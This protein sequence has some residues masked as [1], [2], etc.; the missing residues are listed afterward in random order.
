ML[1]PLPIVCIKVGGESGTVA[2][3]KPLWTTAVC[4]DLA[5]CLP[6]LKI[7]NLKVVQMNLI[8]WLARSGFQLLIPQEK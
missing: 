7:A 1:L 2:Y 5:K 6:K 4:I 3:R 8:M